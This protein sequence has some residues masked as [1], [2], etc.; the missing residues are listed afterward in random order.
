MVIINVLVSVTW[1]K[2]VS[3]S[4]RVLRAK[5]AKKHHH[6]HH[7]QHSFICIYN[8]KVIDDDDEINLHQRKKMNSY[9][10]LFVLWLDF[11]VCIYTFNTQFITQFDINILVV[12]FV[13]LNANIYSTKVNNFQLTLTLWEKILY[14]KKREREKGRVI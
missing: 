11:V 8:V 14:I 3:V 7:H 12:V 2:C 13:H 10:N 5:N 6:H 4:G 1:S 9:V